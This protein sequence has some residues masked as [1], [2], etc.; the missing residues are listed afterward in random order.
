M[1]IADLRERFRA[2]TEERIAAA[3]L[4]AWIDAVEHPQR[5]GWCEGLMALR[6]EGAVR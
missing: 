6:L 4:D 3:R 5:D 2:V 1:T